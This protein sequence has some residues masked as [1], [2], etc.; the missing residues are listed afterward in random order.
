MRVI[1]FLSERLFQLFLVVTT[2]ATITFLLLRFT[3][4]DPAYML[5]SAND[6]AVSENA[7]EALRDDLGLT[8]SIWMQYRQ[9]IV[10]VFTWQW[11]TSYISNEAVVTELLARLPATIE[12]AIAGLIVMVFTTI[13]F[14]LLSAIYSNGLINRVGQ[15]LALL[16]A[17]IPTFWLAFLMIY[18]FSVK[19]GWFPTMG[20]GNMG[21]IILPALSLGIGIGV[22]YARVLRK[23]MLEMM[24]QHFVKALQAAGISQAR[25]LVFHVFKHAA[26]PL[27]TMLGTSFA[28]M[29]SGSIIIETIF[30]WP[31]LGRYIIEAINMRDYPVIQ[32]YVV[33]ATILFMSIHIIVDLV[34]FIIDPRM[35]Y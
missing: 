22:V 33:F 13:S 15:S 17:A 28:F 6:M 29:L 11:G 27:I 20:R 7:L 2:V 32:G 3:P 23:N 31:G 19:L 18:L 16:G 34:Y 14:G 35:R 10:G 25:I 8:D 5:L 9:W 30:S 4:G 12:L 1:W 21:H 26:M 24:N